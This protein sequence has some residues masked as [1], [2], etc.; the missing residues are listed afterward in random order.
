MVSW[1]LRYLFWW[2]LE[3]SLRETAGRQLRSK[4]RGL[5]LVHEVR[6]FLYLLHVHFIASLSVLTFFIVFFVLSVRFDKE[7]QLR[8]LGRVPIE[9]D[10]LHW[11][12]ITCLHANAK[13]I[14]YLW[15]KLSSKLTYLQFTCFR[16]LSLRF[17]FIHCR[18][19]S[20]VSLERNAQLGI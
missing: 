13:D 19:I 14:W 8:K 4:C 6:R 16:Q 10:Q 17:Y 2:W 18:L 11:F 7:V 9:T 20:V 3:V 5:R 15:P 12:M 1:K